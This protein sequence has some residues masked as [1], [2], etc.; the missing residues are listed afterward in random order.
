MDDIISK[1]KNEIMKTLCS[2]ADI[3]RLIPGH[4]ESPTPDRSLIYTHF[5]PFDNIDQCITTAGQYLCFEVD[6][7]RVDS[8]KVLELLISFWVVSSTEPNIV[9]ATGGIR[10]DILLYHIYKALKKNE[11]LGIGRIS[12]IPN[13]PIS[14]F[15][16]EKT[17]AGRAMAL[18]ASDFHIKT[19]DRELWI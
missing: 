5:F 15:V 18:V 8:E 3:V 7:G 13:H 10:N 17:W 9:K 2:D 14:S 12:Y 4:E 11:N 1:Y 6:I 16:P 19:K